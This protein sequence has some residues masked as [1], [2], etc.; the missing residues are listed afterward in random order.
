MVQSFFL[1]D[2][3]IN[4]NI[5]SRTKGKLTKHISLFSELLFSI[6][7][8][9][10]QEFQIQTQDLLSNT[11]RFENAHESLA[12]TFNTAVTLVCPF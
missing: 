6:K 3:H 5:C 11:N 10:S 1:I 9:V 2:N 8:S 12:A 7:C 4:K